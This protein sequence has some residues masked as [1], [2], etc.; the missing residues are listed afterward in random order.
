MASIKMAVAMLWMPF[1]N[2][3]TKGTT[4]FGKCT[5]Q[6]DH[7]AFE[8]KIWAIILGL[9]NHLFWG[10]H[11]GEKRI[12]M[13]NTLNGW[14]TKTNLTWVHIAICTANFFNFGI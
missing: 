4:F 5:H 11:K 13:F 1:Q 3:L 12:A 9:K 14:L 6:I 8:N 7:N 2:N 10:S